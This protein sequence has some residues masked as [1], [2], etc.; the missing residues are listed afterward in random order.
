[1]SSMIIAGVD[2]SIIA[3]LDFQQGI[4]GIGGSTTRRMA[5]GAGYKLTHWRK[6]RISLSAGGWIPAPLN[7]V[8]F[9]ASFEIELPWPVALNTGESL[10]AGWSSRAAPWN[11][12]S[13]TDQAGR[14]VR[15]VWPKMTVFAEPPR[16]SFG[17]DP[18]W[19]LVCET[20]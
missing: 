16:Q 7:A 20:V 4:E 1:M 12:K 10:P 8:N 18:S 13:V 6:H 9:D 2:L 14:T 19:E 5:N 17:P 3:W 15:L 11:E